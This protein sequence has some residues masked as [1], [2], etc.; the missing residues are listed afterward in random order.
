[1]N[2]SSFWWAAAACA[3]AGCSSVRRDQPT[4]E[5]YESTPIETTL[6]HSD[7]RDAHVVWLERIREAS[8]SLDFAHFYASDESGSRLTAVIEAVEEAADRGVKI[9]FL[10]EEKFVKTYPET[11]ARLR[12]RHGIEVRQFDVGK[13]FGHGVLHA[14]YFIADGREVLVGSHNFDY[15]SLTHIV[16]LGARVSALSVV[17]AYRQVFDLDWSLA[18]DAPKAGVAGDGSDALVWETVALENGA[19]VRV[20]PVA[21]PK[22]WLPSGVVWDLPQIR[23]LIDQATSR[24]SVQVLTYRGKDRDGEVLELETALKAAAARGVQV[25]LLVADW[26]KRRGVIEGLQ[27][28]AALPGFTVKMASIPKWSGGEI[29]FARVIHA[30]QCVV[31]GSRAWLGTSNWERG[32]FYESR[33]MGLLL[34][35]PAACGP[36]ESFFDDLWGSSYTEA[37]SPGSA[38]R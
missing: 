8:V 15:R 23:K 20:A 5:L 12:K 34:D 35:G 6:D 13:V 33:N 4:L 29:P 38:V 36:L 30:K 31:D 11:L 9:R 1:M 26:S 19:T 16:E 24:V 2:R 17:K 21:S 10:A 27:E 3:I 7:W 25:R 37:V 28:L 22:G 14:K 32:Y 18:A